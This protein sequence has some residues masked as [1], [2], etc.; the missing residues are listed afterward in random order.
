MRILAALLVVVTLSTGCA[1][2]ARD[3]RFGAQQPPPPISKPIQVGPKKGNHPV[4][5]GALIGY[6][7]LVGLGLVAV[8]SVM[9]VAA[10]VPPLD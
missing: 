10:I 6:G 5:K 9:L 2:V 8:L 4:L 7:A 3:Y 1:A